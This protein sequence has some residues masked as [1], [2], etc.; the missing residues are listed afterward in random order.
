MPLFF[1]FFSMIRR[2]PRSTLFPYTTL[3]RSL[4]SPPRLRSS[5][6]WWTATGL[7]LG[8]AFTSKYTSILVPIAVTLAVV[9]RRE[10]R[11]RLA[12]VGPYVACVLAAL[13]LVPVLRW[14]ASHEWVSFAFQLRHGLGAPS[15]SVFT[16][17]VRNELDYLGGQAGLAT[18]TLIVILATA[19]PRALRRDAAAYV[20]AVIAAVYFAF[21]AY[22][23]LRQRVEPNWPAAAYVPAIALIAACYPPGRWMKA[24][25]WL[26]GAVSL[27]VYVQAIVP[28]LPVRPPRDP[29]ARAFGWR[30]L[31][32]RTAAAA[33]ELPGRSWFGGDRYQ[34]A[35]ELAFYL[36]D[37]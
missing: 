34:E 35:S 1:L 36:P 37:H 30:E 28:V 6:A 2:P 18:P 33:K 15:G 29:I 5:L 21:F 3:F 13:V 7:A 27:A 31:A 20:L 23:A 22:S 8:V 14:N 9:T 4:Q 11:P 17:A 24:G 32:Q 19:V 25:L 12:E 26:A 10:L 16:T